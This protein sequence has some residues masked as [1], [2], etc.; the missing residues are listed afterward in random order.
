MPAG[1]RIRSRA[2]RRGDRACSAASRAKTWE[3][4][5]LTACEG[6]VAAEVATDL[7]MRIGAVYQ[8]KS[9]LMQ[10]LQDEV[11]KLEDASGLARGPD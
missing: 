1:S 4:Y 6:R 11:R 7:G 8:A 10:M 2:L 9:R 5:H 3:A